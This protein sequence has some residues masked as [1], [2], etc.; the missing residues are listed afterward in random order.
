M[1]RVS[2]HQAT[3]VPRAQR[4]FLSGLLANS[5]NAQRFDTALWQ[6]NQ[7]DGRKRHEDSQPRDPA[8]ASRHNNA[9][10]QIAR[11]AKSQRAATESCMQAL[12]KQAQLVAEYLQALS[13]IQ[14]HFGAAAGAEPAQCGTA[15]QSARAQEL[16]ALID[17][18]VRFALL[19]DSE[20][21]NDERIR[22]VLAPELFHNTEFT[23]QHSD[24]GWHLDA[25][26]SSPECCQLLANEAGVLQEKFAARGLGQIAVSIT[27]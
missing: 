8:P 19:A 6:A 25:H 17:R 14:T 27:R 7:R 22:I 15:L 1:H 16:R 26:S 10:T 18:C 9:D 13:A 3:S 20:T 11:S 4:A 23:L 12:N 24:E 21:A 2:E 5:A